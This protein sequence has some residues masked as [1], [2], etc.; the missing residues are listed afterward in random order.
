MLKMSYARCPGLSPAILAQFTL[1][2]CVTAGNRKKNSLK[3]PILGVQGHSRSS[4][5][6]IKNLSLLLVMI[7]SMSVPICNRFHATRA[8]IDIHRYCKNLGPRLVI[9]QAVII[10]NLC[11]K[12]PLT[13]KPLNDI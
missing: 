8:N 11:N 2:M 10:I 1:K 9:L 12:T 7:C 6:P 4:R 5:S 13:P 3:T